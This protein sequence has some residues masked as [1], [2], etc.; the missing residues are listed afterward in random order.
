MKPSN[1]NPNGF[2]ASSAL[3]AATLVAI[4]AAFI[5][6]PTLYKYSA[7][8]VLTL[9]ADGWGYEFMGLYDL[10]WRILT[11]LLIFLPTRTAVYLGVMALSTGA[12]MRLAGV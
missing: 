9:V 8:T 4:V 7:P 12:F 2:L 1:Q 6:A 5:G 11:F 3:N 10:G